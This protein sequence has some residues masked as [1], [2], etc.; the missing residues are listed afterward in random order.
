MSFGPHQVNTV[1]PEAVIHSFNQLVWLIFPL[2]WP[3]CRAVW[4]SAGTFTQREGRLLRNLLNEGDSFLLRCA[5][6]YWVTVG[7]SYNHIPPPKPVPFLVFKMTVWIYKTPKMLNGKANNNCV[8]IYTSVFFRR[9]Y[10]FYFRN[11]NK[12]QHEEDKQFAT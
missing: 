11:T 8:F 9:T 6:D 3:K 4:A 7:M 2:N 5:T 10:F 12:R 1:F